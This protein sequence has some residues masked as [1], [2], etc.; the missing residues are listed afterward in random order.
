MELVRRATGYRT[1]RR[2]VTPGPTDV[3]Q[4]YWSRSHL[5]SV[6]LELKVSLSQ[7]ALLYKMGQRSEK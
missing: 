1:W 5:R 7:V 6:E 2:D 3:K 4:Q